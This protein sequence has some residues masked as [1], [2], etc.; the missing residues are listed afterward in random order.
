MPLSEKGHQ[1][2]G[3]DEKGQSK[4]SRMKTKKK[5]VDCILNLFTALETYKNNTHG[6]TASVGQRK[7]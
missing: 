6:H 1:F 4:K 2:G 7:I 5:S 3:G